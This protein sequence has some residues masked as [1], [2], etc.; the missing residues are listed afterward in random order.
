MAGLSD[1]VE[2][3]RTMRKLS[4]PLAA[5]ALGGTMILGGHATAFAQDATPI[6]VDPAECVVA[7]RTV[8]ELVTIFLAGDYAPDEAI[9]AGTFPE[10]AEAPADVVDGVNATMRQVIACSNAN[11]FL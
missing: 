3:E 8:D 7:P 5:L 1:G 6:A 9:V 11:D 4:G 2:T 10:G